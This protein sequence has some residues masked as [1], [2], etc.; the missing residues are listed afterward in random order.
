MFLY[1]FNVDYYMSSK[2]Y[3]Y[4]SKQE[5][6]DL[7]ISWLTLSLAFAIV[8]S[9]VFLGISEFIV[10]FPIALVAVGTGFILH[11][12]AHRQMAR[13]FGFQSEFRAWYPGLVF[14]FFIAII[15]RGGF[16][17]AAPG[18]TYFFGENV[19]VEQEAKISIAGPV[20]N[21]IVGL[22][23][24]FLFFFSAGGFFSLILLLA[25]RMNFLFAFFNLIPFGPLDGRKV[26]KW[27]FSA[28]LITIL[29]SGSLFFFLPYLI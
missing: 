13:K 26:L 20:V 7:L 17:F 18:A 3:W 5:K 14:A 27:N 8:I 11:E 16:I 10:S 9:P 22:I 6:F 25:S 2:S 29:I 21:I 19:S 1:L 12:M 15:T 23:L 28:W 4:F 24:L